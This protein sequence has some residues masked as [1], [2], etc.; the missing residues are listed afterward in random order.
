MTPLDFAAMTW[1][2]MVCGAERPDA[3]IS[4]RVR[5]VEHEGRIMPGASYNQKYCN[6]R[7][8]CIA[9]AAEPGPYRIP[10]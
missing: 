6:D 9:A 3:A 1:N 7:P 8:A 10:S 5:E 4:V 2:C